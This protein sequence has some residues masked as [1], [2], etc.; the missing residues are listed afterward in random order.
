MYPH[1]AIK[2]TSYVNDTLLV[3]RTTL[4]SVSVMYCLVDKTMCEPVW[5]SGKALGW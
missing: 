4:R 5:P 2:I 1:S 3:D